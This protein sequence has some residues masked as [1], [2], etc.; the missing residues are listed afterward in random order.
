MF[1]D[2]NNTDNLFEVGSDSFGMTDKAPKGSISPHEF[3]V[4]CCEVDNQI[5]AKAQRYV[6]VKDVFKD[7]EWKQGDKLSKAIRDGR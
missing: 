1:Y 7:V 4:E 6:D 2:R 3:S 5:Y